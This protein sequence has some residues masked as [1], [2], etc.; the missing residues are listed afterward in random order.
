MYADV[1]PGGL[2]GERRWGPASETLRTEA[3]GS[4]I[5]DRGTQ[6]TEA[7]R[8]LACP[9]GGEASPCPAEHRFEWADW[10]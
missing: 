5:C 6:K 8:R 1:V 10:N 4:V 7:G 3:F 9:G 2:T